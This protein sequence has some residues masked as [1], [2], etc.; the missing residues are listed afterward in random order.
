ML[1]FKRKAKTFKYKIE[2][3]GDA[4]RFRARRLLGGIKWRIFRH[5]MLFSLIMLV[6]LW[7]AQTVFLDTIYK[8]VKTNDMRHVS[9]EISQSLQAHG[10]ESDE[11][12]D[13]MYAVARNNYMCVLVAKLTP[14]AGLNLQAQSVDVNA[15]CIIHELNAGEVLALA[16]EAA[17]KLAAQPDEDPFETFLTL[18]EG[19]GDHAGQ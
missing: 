14:D 10:F 8:Q 9:Q 13:V 19:G 7:L 17:K 1:S 11:L 16:A 12:S 3:A 6:L 4:G 5:F 18:S 2:G 15:L